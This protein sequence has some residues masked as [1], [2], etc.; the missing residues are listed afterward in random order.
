[1][2]RRELMKVAAAGTAA[3]ALAG[4]SAS[5]QVLPRV[6]LGT[7]ITF[8]VGNDPQLLRRSRDVVAAFVK[9]GGG[10]VDS[11][12]MY[13]SSQE[14]LGFALADLGYP[15]N[16]FSADKV[17]T[18]SIRNGP[19]QIDESRRQWGI[20]RFDLVQVHN[21]VGWEGHLETLQAMK[22]E[23]KIGEIGITTSHG[24]RHGEFEQVMRRMS[25]D[26]VQFT[27]NPVDREAEQA[28]LPLARERGIR[29]IATTGRSGAV[30]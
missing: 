7:W 13:G 9:A 20:E 10:M 29:V 23:E 11:S 18:G 16:V 1:M 21:L 14:T 26:F 8:N 4:F 17:W 24:R 28:L 3:T 5:A 19:E 25:L 15:E 12:P 27:Y 2:N 6:G 22:A 30:R